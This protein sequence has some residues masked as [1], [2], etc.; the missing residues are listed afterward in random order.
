MKYLV[1]L[2]FLLIILSSFIYPSADVKV[3]EWYGNADGALSITFDD[4]DENQYLLAY[5]LMEKYGIKGSFGI[6]TSWV[7][8]TVEEPEN[9]LI[10][11]MSWEQI[12]SLGD[13]EIASHSCTHALLTECNEK[14]LL[15]EI[16]NSKRIIEGHTKKKCITMHYPYSQTNEEIKEI[17]ENSGYLCA[18]TLD[19]KINTDPDLYEIAS[20]AAFDDAHP[21]LEELKEL[22][23]ETKEE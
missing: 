23:N 9:V 4:G 5:P 18:R 16:H 17:L 21:S 3:A 14:E 22:I 20:Y 8:K 6:V 13:S 7:G 19:S 15:A 12:C 10:R 11:R 2:I 1:S